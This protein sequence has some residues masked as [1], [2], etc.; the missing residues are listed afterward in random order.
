QMDEETQQNSA[1]VEE[2]AA[3]AKTLEEQ[4]A[5]M[6]ERVG[7]FQVGAQDVAPVAELDEEEV[8]QS[9]SAR[10][11]A[12]PV[13]RRARPMTRGNLALSS[14]PAGDFQEF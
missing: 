4:Q 11:P 13:A 2:N 1:L 8:V 9:A 14:E 7:Y 5:A 3:T 12:A 10:R 6:N